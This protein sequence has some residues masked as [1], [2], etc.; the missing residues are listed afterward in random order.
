MTTTLHLAE[1]IIGTI[2]MTVDHPRA[3]ES[4]EGSRECVRLSI[5]FALGI[6]HLWVTIGSLMY[7]APTALLTNR[8]LLQSR[9][10]N[11]EDNGEEA[12]DEAGEVEVQY[13]IEDPSHNHTA[14]EATRQR[15]VGDE[16]ALD[17]ESFAAHVDTELVAHNL[18]PAH[19]HVTQVTSEIN[20]GRDPDDDDDSDF[21]VATIGLL[22]VT[23]VAVCALA[24]LVVHMT[25]VCATEGE[26]WNTGSFVD[27]G[28]GGN[29]SIEMA[30]QRFSYDPAFHSFTDMGRASGK[31]F[32]T[33]WGTVGGASKE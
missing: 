23:L 3:F 30:K 24:G 18:P 6:N 8:R 26:H 20:S 5:A 27:D 9:Q 22:V 16:H 31:D 33:N 2:K 19:P 13:V 14:L 11:G 25:G 1:Q 4:S 12:G 21:G 29:K 15:I 10:E 7:N 28:E 17:D 32:P